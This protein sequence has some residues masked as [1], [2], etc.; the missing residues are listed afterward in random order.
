MVAGLTSRL[1]AA[2]FETSSHQP[3]RLQAARLPDFK[4]PDFQTLQKMLKRRI[5][6]QF[7]MRLV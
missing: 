6:E 3:S 5:S 7:G 1:N 2:R 4:P